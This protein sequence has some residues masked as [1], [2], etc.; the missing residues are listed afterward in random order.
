MC[1]IDNQSVCRNGLDSATALDITV[2]LRRWA[3]RTRGSVLAAMLQP[4]PEVY[5]L[6]DNVLLLKEGRVIYFGPRP[7]VPVYLKKQ[8]GIKVPSTRDYADFVF[9]FLI[10]PVVS[11][12]L[13]HR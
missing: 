6:F 4:T 9:E 8:F 10:D 13:C 12:L 7:A 5:E 11:L 2:T 1:T 3:R